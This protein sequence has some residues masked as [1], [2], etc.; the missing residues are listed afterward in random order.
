MARVIR[1]NKL[2]YIPFNL[3]VHDDLL[4]LAFGDIV[5]CR[6]QWVP[7]DNSTSTI[8][9][10]RGIIFKPICFGTNEIVSDA[11]QFYFRALDSPIAASL[12]ASLNFC[13]P[14]TVIHSQLRVLQ[15]AF[16]QW[17]IWIVFFLSL[18][19]NIARYSRIWSLSGHVLQ[20]YEMLVNL[21]MLAILPLLPLTIP[22]FLLFARSFG[23]AQI[24]A[25]YD[26]LQS[27]QTEFEDKDDVDEFDVA[28]PPTK[29]LV[30]DR[31]TFLFCH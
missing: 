7:L 17:I 30:L 9:L 18:G 28:P 6:A 22:S 26:A 1:S 11:G 2:H 25:L 14:E 12:Q 15:T 10:E 31:G 27:S 16:S 5:P 8:T 3:I 4:Q 13:R 24:L 19:I 21:Q 29:N 23:N 20:G